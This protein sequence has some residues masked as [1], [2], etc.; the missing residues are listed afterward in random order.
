MTTAVTYSTM[1]SATSMQ[2]RNL[3]KPMEGRERSVGNNTL[4]ETVDPLGWVCWNVPV[5]ADYFAWE[6]SRVNICRPFIVLLEYSQGARATKKEVP[7]N[8]KCTK[9][10]DFSKKKPWGTN[11][12]YAKGM[13]SLLRKS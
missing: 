5:G 4:N 10:H 2:I 3:N 6:I 1:K 7:D 8:I 13:I 9:Y 12:I 11:I